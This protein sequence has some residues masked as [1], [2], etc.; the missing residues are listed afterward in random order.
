MESP[1]GMILMVAS[2]ALTNIMLKKNI[3]NTK[4][5]KHAFV[6]ITHF[7]SHALLKRSS[8]NIYQLKIS[9]VQ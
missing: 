4:E 1:K 8:V 6:F 3:K 9:K 5:N 7:L 2:D